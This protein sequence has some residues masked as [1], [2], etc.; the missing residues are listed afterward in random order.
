MKKLFIH[1]MTIFNIIILFPSTSS[2][3]NFVY[4]G[5]CFWCT[6]ADTEK[7]NGV[8]EVI[9]GFTGGTSKNPKYIP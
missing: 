3:D 2:A 8:S 4:S 6:E 5:G 1:F 7:L 9:S